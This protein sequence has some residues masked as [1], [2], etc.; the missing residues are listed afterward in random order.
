MFPAMSMRWTKST[1][2]D[3][4]QVTGPTDRGLEEASLPFTLVTNCLLLTMRGQRSSWQSQRMLSSPTLM[5]TSKLKL[6]LEHLSL[7]TWRLAEWLFYK[8]GCKGRFTGSLIRREEK[9]PDRRLEE[10]MSQTLGSSLGSKGFKW[11]IRHPSPG[12]P[13]HHRDELS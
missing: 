13:H 9:H 10:G 5:N 8:Q 3:P 6:H 12:V 1:L 4:S 2:G 7:K 11:H